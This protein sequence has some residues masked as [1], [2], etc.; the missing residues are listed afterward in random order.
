MYTCPFEEGDFLMP[1]RWKTKKD[2]DEAVVVIMNVLDK[3]A[4]PFPNWLART[5]RGAMADSDPGMV[6][7]FYQ[8]LEKYAPG[9]LK[10]FET[11]S[12]HE[13]G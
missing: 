12:V 4:D 2:V 8:E 3:G 6:K 9:A 5:I 11:D 13:T 10:V 1:Y 7:Y